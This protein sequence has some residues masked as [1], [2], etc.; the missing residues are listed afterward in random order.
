MADAMPHATF[1]WFAAAGHFSFLD[2]PTQFAECF[3]GWLAHLGNEH[4]EA[5][6]A[7]VHPDLVQMSSDAL[8]FPVGSGIALPV[9]SRVSLLVIATVISFLVSSGIGLAVI[10]SGRCMRR[11]SHEPLLLAAH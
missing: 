3:Q 4:T 7:A 8:S 2:Q 9:D 10:C 1:Q 5:S 11:A 6:A